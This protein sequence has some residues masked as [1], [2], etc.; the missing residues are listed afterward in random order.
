MPSNFDLIGA[1][2]SLLL[3]MPCFPS[4]SNRKSH[5]FREKENAC[6][7][8]SFGLSHS[9][10]FFVFFPPFFPF[11]ILFFPTATEANRKNSS[12]FKAAMRPAVEISL[13]EHDL[14]ADDVVK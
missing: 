2:I 4:L 11:H 5:S 6:F 10:S 8:L 9:L 3:T 1:F 13:L 7:S 12:S 14:S